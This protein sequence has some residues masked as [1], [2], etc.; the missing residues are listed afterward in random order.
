MQLFQRK[1]STPSSLPS[2]SKKEKLLTSP[3]MRSDSQYSEASFPEPSITLGEAEQH[4]QYELTVLKAAHDNLGSEAVLLSAE[5]QETK[6]QAEALR[7]QLKLAADRLTP[8]PTPRPRASTEVALPDGNVSITS[9]LFQ[10]P[11]ESFSVDGASHN[12]LPDIE[13]ESQLK[14]DDFKSLSAVASK[15]QRAHAEIERL[16]YLVIQAQDEVS[17]LEIELKYKEDAL[18]ALKAERSVDYITATEKKAEALEKALR[19]TQEEFSRLKAELAA[20]EEALEA[21]G[22]AQGLTAAGEVQRLQELRKRSEATIKALEMEMADKDHALQS[23]RSTVTMEK[24]AAKSEYVRLEGA[25]TAAHR[26]IAGL[27]YELHNQE[28]IIQ[29]ANN[30][31]L[32]DIASKASIE[33]IERMEAEVKRLRTL[34]IQTEA[35]AAEAL[36]AANEK[37]EEALKEKEAAL[38]KAS[39][40]VSNI[41]VWAIHCAA[42]QVTIQ[43]LLSSIEEK[44][45]IQADL[46]TTIKKL[47]LSRNVEVQ[48]VHDLSST[49]LDAADE[50]LEAIAVEPRLGQDIDQM[51]SLQSCIDSKNNSEDTAAIDTADSTVEGP[52]RN[53]PIAGDGMESNVHTTLT[54][55]AAV[56][57]NSTSATTAATRS[58]LTLVPSYGR[59]VNYRSN[60]TKNNLMATSPTSSDGQRSVS[61]GP[62][63]VKMGV[64]AVA[65]AVAS[66]AVAAGKA[67]PMI[68]RGKGK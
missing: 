6:A 29:A 52:L 68:G 24:I 12:L 34:Q 1:S 18:Q 43:S 50:D 60:L 46:E 13:E 28:K 62:W 49:Y 42:L 19:Q 10:T 30:I 35:E 57:S 45:T 58:K 47:R 53:I 44:E 4:L 26:E 38:L 23:L 2:S 36:K 5:L 21:A 37:T 15:T 7:A 14:A 33:V 39:T 16:Q 56:H 61:T 51:L 31:D 11:A 66:M 17:R 3:M 27:R 20:K 25:L 41:Q 32:K 59:S 9:S 40:T 8:S 65:A 67:R 48:A 63:A 64:V 55:I 54:A 22:S